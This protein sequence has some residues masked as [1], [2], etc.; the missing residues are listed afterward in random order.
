MPIVTLLFGKKRGRPGD[1]DQQ[2]ENEKT[3]AIDLGICSK[4]LF[5][6]DK[7]FYNE[8]KDCYICPMGQPMKYV[9]DSI[10]K[11]STGFLQTSRKYQAQ[12]CYN[13]PLT[14]ASHKS[15]GNRILQINK[16]LERQKKQAYQ[17]LNSEDGIAH[18]KKRCYDVEPIF[19]NINRI[20]EA[21]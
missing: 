15:Q 10:R 5:S 3:A 13:C 2:R 12:N 19:G 11:T 17:L 16:E 8:E 7:L 9:G 21:K 6:A 1:P 18:R 20:A 14:G 4:H